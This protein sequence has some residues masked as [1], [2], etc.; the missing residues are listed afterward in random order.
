MFKL[1]SF[2]LLVT[3]GLWCGSAAGAIRVFA[4][5]D[6]SK[7]IYAGERFVYYII[8]DGD[9]RPGLVDL[10]PLVKYDPQ[11][12]GDT[13]R[14]QRKITIINNR[15]SETVVKQY[16]MAYQLTAPEAGTLYLPG[17]DV[18][19]DGQV[20]TTNPVELKI[21]EPETTDKLDLV[22]S[23]SEEQCYVAQPMIMT[24][25]WYVGAQLAQANGAVK[26]VVFNLPVMHSEDFYVEDI[27]G[28]KPTERRIEH[29]GVDSIEIVFRK[30]LIAKRPG[31][32]KIKPGSVSADIAVGRSRRSN[33]FFGSRYQYGRFMTSSA[34][35]TL[36]VLPLPEGGKP[37]GFYG[38][39]GKYTISTT[40]IP[41]KVSVGDPITLTIR[42]S[43][44][45][46][47]K[48]I[49]WPKLQD[50][51]ALAENFRIPEQYSS[52]IVEDGAMVFTQTIRANNSYVT[53]IP[54]IPL[55]Y[56]DVS[57][58]EYVTVG[59]K[60]IALDVAET[61]IVTT[62]DAQGREATAAGREVEAIKKGLSANYE[63]SDI[64]VSQEFSVAKNL[65]SPG[66]LALWLG[67]LALLAVS[68]LVKTAGYRTEERVAAKRRR[69]ACGKAVAELK[70]I[71]KTDT[72]GNRN[73]SQLFAN[74]MKQYIGERFD[75][76]GRS[77]TG[78]ECAQII[79]ERIA[80]SETAGAFGEIIE[81]CEAVY[82]SGAGS[83]FDNQEIARA[84]ELI[85]RIDKKAGK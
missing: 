57:K 71:V 13:D 85:R 70:R 51:A 56:F 32:I 14:S 52:G 7:T 82:Y 49:E 27:D 28:E 18:S 45:E 58:G 12:A 78:A 80:E 21:A 22:I 24:V 74:A 48:P 53:E 38:L 54:P 1:L 63:G 29:N 65:T 62:A 79:I 64:L 5:V 2:S 26:N 20:Y 42:I 83:E 81:Y 43:G 68:A 19:I 50:T 10:E 76:P 34:P 60:P 39:V 35:L 36:N 66:Y 6:S 16:Q 47:L 41:V 69:G 44:S 46:Y 72:G 23:L 75:K 67:P 31:R 73:G 30:V 40:A 11:S 17:I 3:A 9:N 25:K 33:F 59:S 4:Q 55:V 37:A 61:N 15:R 8:I 77:L 84:I